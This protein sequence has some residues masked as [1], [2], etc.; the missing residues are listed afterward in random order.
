MLDV[1][2]EAEATICATMGNMSQS[3]VRFE[4]Y[5][6][7]TIFGKVASVSSLSAH[8]EV[9]AGGTDFRL[10]PVALPGFFGVGFFF[11]AGFCGSLLAWRPR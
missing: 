3:L 9:V 5:W 11:G 7:K 4:P 6:E 10:A 1:G 8:G 2:I